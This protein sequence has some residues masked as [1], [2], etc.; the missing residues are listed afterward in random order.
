M[1]TKQEQIRE[2]LYILTLGYFQ[3]FYDVMEK[4]LLIKDFPND[5][6]CDEVLQ[7]LHD[8]NA[9]IKVEGE[10]PKITPKEYPLLWEATSAQKAQQDMLDAGYTL[11]KGLI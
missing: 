9:V 8:N 6:L 4:G 11:T 5:T 7:C 3:K 1:V 10:L 2:E